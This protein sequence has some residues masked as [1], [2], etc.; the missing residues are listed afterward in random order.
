VRRSLGGDLL[1]QEL[2]DNG[3]RIIDQERVLLKERQARVLPFHVV[4]KRVAT[5]PSPIAARLRAVNAVREVLAD[6]AF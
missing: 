6:M 5:V 1:I 3:I 2:L 4:S